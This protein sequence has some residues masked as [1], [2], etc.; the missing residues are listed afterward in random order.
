MLKHYLNILLFILNC[1]V[2]FYLFKESNFFYYA[3]AISIFIFVVILSCGVLFLKFNYFLTATTSLKNGYCLLTFDDGPDPIY[4]PQILKVLRE[5]NIKALFFIIGK[6]AL[7]NPA[8]VKQ[9]QAEGHLIGN[10]TFNHNIFLSLLPKKQILKEIH[11]GDEAI[12]SIINQSTMYFRPPIGYTNPNYARVL[13]K[14]NLNT[15]GW[16][17]RS[18]DTVYKQESKLIHRL[19]NAIKKNDIVLFHDNL[20]I[21]NNILPTFIRL[22]KE[23]DIIFVPLSYNE[24]VFND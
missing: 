6:K 15:I 21:T 10:H 13:K 8:L 23:K 4:T 3:L 19:I 5:E 24:N 17:L 1:S 2:S 7:E 14:L 16:S 9:I 12:Q 22:A 11:E 18:Y 20:E